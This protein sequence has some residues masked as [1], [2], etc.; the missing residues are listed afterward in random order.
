M[1]ICPSFLAIPDSFSVQAVLAPYW[2][3]PAKAF[4]RRA[5]EGQSAG[6]GRHCAR[7]SIRAS[8]ANDIERLAS[9]SLSI[10]VLLPQSETSF[11]HIPVDLK[12]FPNHLATTG[13][14]FFFCLLSLRQSPLRC[15]NCLLSNSDILSGRVSSH[16]SGAETLP[17]SLSL[18]QSTLA[19]T[20]TSTLL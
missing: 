2:L 17:F 15:I 5:F 19:K 12:T 1:A 10:P 11:Q 9:H 13:A 16:S 3:H 7:I 8:G 18:Q 14:C 4:P 20:V 6:H